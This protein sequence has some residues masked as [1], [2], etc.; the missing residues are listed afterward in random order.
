MRLTEA[1]AELDQIYTPSKKDLNEGRSMPYALLVLLDGKWKVYK[2]LDFE[3]TDDELIGFL[4]DKPEYTDAKVIPAA[5]IQKYVQSRPLL[6]EDGWLSREELIAELEKLGYR[7]K[8]DKYSD[9][10]L[11]C[12]LENTKAKIELDRALAELEKNKPNNKPICN[13]CGST[14]TDGGVCP[15]CYDGALDLDEGILDS[16]SS[17]MLGWTTTPSAPSPSAATGN[18]LVKTSPSS[19]KIVTIFYDHRAG[20]LRAQANDGVNG[21]ANVAFPNHLRTQPGQQ[22][23]VDNL[24]WN[25]K[26]YRVSGNVKPI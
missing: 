25:G 26:N 17:G 2:G 18:N 7:Y 14:L 12:I 4:S 20:K 6:K 1:F 13:D 10:Q 16:K 22:Y 21:T 11:Y 19:N 5:D 8:F 23:E 15:R 9:R 3:L 24:I